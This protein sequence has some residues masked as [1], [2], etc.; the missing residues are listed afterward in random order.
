M[1]YCV[2]LYVLTVKTA[3]FDLPLTPMSE[4]ICGKKYIE[5]SNFLGSKVTPLW[6]WGAAYDIV[7][8]R[9]AFGS[10]GR[11]GSNPSIAVIFTL[12]ISVR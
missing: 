1:R 10:D 9:F 2:C 11:A 4:S 3:I 5:K 12:F 6:Q 7:V 8:S